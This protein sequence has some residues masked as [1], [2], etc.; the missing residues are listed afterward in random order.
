MLKTLKYTIQ[1]QQTRK[2][3]NTTE[4]V[5]V[6]MILTLKTLII[7]IYTSKALAPK[8]KIY[9]IYLVTY[10]NNI[11]ITTQS[12]KTINTSA[13]THYKTGLN[14]SINYPH[15]HKSKHQQQ[16]LKSPKTKVHNTQTHSNA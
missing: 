1:I 16:N 15:H 3:V 8:H 13:Y 14:T 2:T 9:T 12:A 4:C 7:R 6:Y 11:N 5:F 10:L